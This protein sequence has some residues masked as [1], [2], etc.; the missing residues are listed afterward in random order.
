[1]VVSHR[2]QFTLTIRNINYT[3]YTITLTE[4]KTYQLIKKDN[5]N[6][7]HYPYNHY[8]EYIDNDYI[9]KFLNII[10]SQSTI[11]YLWLLIVLKKETLSDDLNL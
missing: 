4:N 2:A 8:I 10:F 6:I 3:F 9:L 1:M 5:T 7:S 11:F